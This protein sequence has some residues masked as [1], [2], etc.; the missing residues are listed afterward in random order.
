[1]QKVLALAFK[2]CA[3]G[4]AV[5][6]AH[7]AAAAAHASAAA[8]PAW[9]L[10]RFSV[11]SLASPVVQAALGSTHVRDLHLHLLPAQFTPALCEALARLHG[12]QMLSAVCGEGPMFRPAQLQRLI[13]TLQRLPQLAARIVPRF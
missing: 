2:P 10:A 3:C 4:S 11:G 9:R 1:M 13:M 5:Q 12:L 7:P 8:L 6:Q